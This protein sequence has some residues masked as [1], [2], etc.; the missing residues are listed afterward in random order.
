ML[1][2]ALHTGQVLGL[3]LYVCP[4]MCGCTYYLCAAD[5]KALCVILLSIISRNQAQSYHNKDMAWPV[6][7]HTHTLAGTGK[8]QRVLPLGFAW[9]STSPD[10]VTSCCVSVCD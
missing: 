8:E 10:N 4:T 6:L 7:T 2:H 1:H 3:M 9:A 5:L